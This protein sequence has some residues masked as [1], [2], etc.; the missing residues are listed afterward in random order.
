MAM[1]AVA[2]EVGAETIEMVEVLI[3]IMVAEIVLDHTKN[4]LIRCS[5]KA[6]L[7]QGYTTA[8]VVY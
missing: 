6:L 5:K 1:E 8:G 7:F 4:D 2:M 3:G